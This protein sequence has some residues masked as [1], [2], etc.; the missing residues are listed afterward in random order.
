MLMIATMVTIPTH[1]T[2]TITISV[3]MII[4]S[5]I[6]VIIQLNYSTKH[7]KH[8]SQ[9]KDHALLETLKCLPLTFV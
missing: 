6:I 7:L 8:V 3:I 4:I 1:I 2:I 5:V 9:T